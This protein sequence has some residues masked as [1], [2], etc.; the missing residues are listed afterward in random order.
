MRVNQ[1]PEATELVPETPEERELLSRLFVRIHPDP[2][3]IHAAAKLDE[4]GT[5][6]LWK[7]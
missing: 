6:V 3:K 7:F 4:S 2:Q 1:V 5:L